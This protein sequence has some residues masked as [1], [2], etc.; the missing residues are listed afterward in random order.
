MNQLISH[1]IVFSESLIR[2]IVFNA[3]DELYVYLSTKTPCLVTLCKYVWTFSRPLLCHCRLP[4][5]SLTGWTLN[6]LTEERTKVSHT[7]K[8]AAWRVF[9]CY[10]LKSKRDKLLLM[11][12]VFRCLIDLTWSLPNL[13]L[14][15][16]L[17]LISVYFPV[18]QKW[19]SHLKY[20][21]IVFLCHIY[22]HTSQ[23]AG[24]ISL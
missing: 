21:I 9:L 17:V 10:F 13:F 23:Y 11:S 18:G 22:S 3:L 24:S 1:Y 4:A 5:F 20:D 15:N 16:I 19:L 6:S 2:S 8:V 7:C 12:L 14:L